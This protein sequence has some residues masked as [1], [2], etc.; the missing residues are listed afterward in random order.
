MNIRLQGFLLH[1]FFDVGKKFFVHVLRLFWQYSLLA[2]FFFFKKICING[3]WLRIE[4]NLA[5]GS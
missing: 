2:E 1:G 4:R 5:T 3:R